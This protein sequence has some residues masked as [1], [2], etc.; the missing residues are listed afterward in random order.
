MSSEGKSSVRRKYPELPGVQGLSRHFRRAEDVVHADAFTV[1]SDFLLPSSLCV[2]VLVLEQCGN[3]NICFGEFLSNWNRPPWNFHKAN[4]TGENH[5]FLSIRIFH[6]DF[7]ISS[8]KNPKYF[9]TDY[10]EVKE[11]HCI[12][13][14][15][16]WHLKMIIIKNQT[17]I[18]H[19]P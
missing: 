14:T 4:D 16:C 17:E 1:F 3:Q 18:V 19:P 2:L 6:I 12:L 8:K 7:C 10:P 13:K 11:K 5:H 15:D 9:E